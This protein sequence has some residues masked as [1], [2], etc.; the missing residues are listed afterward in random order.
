MKVTFKQ[1]LSA[2]LALRGA[3]EPKDPV[4]KKIIWVL[5]LFKKER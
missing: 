4:V 3:E 1:V 5:K 2:K